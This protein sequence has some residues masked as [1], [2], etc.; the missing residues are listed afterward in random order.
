MQDVTARQGALFAIAALCGRLGR[1]SE[2]YMVQLT[3][4]AF[5]YF[6]DIFTVIAWLSS[7]M[8]QPQSSIRTV[9]RM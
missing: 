9:C 8:L 4:L 3:I 2:P 7:S 6:S 5:P 1:L